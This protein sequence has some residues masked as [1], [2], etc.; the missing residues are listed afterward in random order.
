MLAKRF[1]APLGVFGG[2]IDA[3]GGG[4]WGPMGTPAIL[5]GGR[6]QPRKAIGSIDTSEFLI[7]VATSAGFFVGLGC[8]AATGSTRRTPS[9]TR[10]T[11]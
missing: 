10:S 3:I 9:G 8:C 7:A 1:L 5:A 2:F 6:L 11:R 4:G